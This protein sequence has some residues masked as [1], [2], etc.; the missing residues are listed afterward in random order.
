LCSRHFL[1]HGFSNSSISLVN[2]EFEKSVIV[3]TYA[4]FNKMD[5]FDFL[6]KFKNSLIVEMFSLFLFDKNFYIFF[7]LQIV[8][9]FYRKVINFFKVY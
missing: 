4:F 6:K 5:L 7:L 9:I 2:N 3:S 8:N 1:I